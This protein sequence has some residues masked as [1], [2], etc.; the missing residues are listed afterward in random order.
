MAKTKNVQIPQAAYA[1]EFVYNGEKLDPVQFV[2][3]LE[4]AFAEQ[5]RWKSAFFWG[6]DNGNRSHRS[7]QDRKD[8]HTD[9][10]EYNG[11]EYCY[12]VDVS[13]SR[14]NTYV[15]RNTFTMD[16]GGDIRAWKKVRDQVVNAHPDLFPDRFPKKTAEPV[17]TEPDVTTKPTAKPA[18]EKAPAKNTVD[19]LDVS[20]VARSYM[21][22]NVTLYDGT[23]AILMFD[24]SE[25]QNRENDQVVVWGTYSLVSAIP[26]DSAEIKDNGIE[27]YSCTGEGPLS[28]KGYDDE[29]YVF[30]E[31]SVRGRIEDQ[32][33]RID[34]LADYVNSPF[35]AKDTADAL[36]V[37][38]ELASS[39]HAFDGDTFTTD[40]Y[41]RAKSPALSDMLDTLDTGFIRVSDQNRSLDSDEYWRIENAK[42]RAIETNLDA[43]HELEQQQESR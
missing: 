25:W 38:D 13:R 28:G 33:D 40:R 19:S 26:A 18:K 35:D 6:G 43:R 29:P 9:V 39:K 8:S 21:V 27:L 23:P 20:D 34:F 2:E 17:K 16:G 4:D 5:E 42:S 12:Q 24:V 32:V 41:G 31:E 15:N 22:G 11:H 3:K 1:D 30:R 36:G 10:F 37:A 14:K 7:W